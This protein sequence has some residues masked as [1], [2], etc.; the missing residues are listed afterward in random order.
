MTRVVRIGK[1]PLIEKAVGH[2]L[3][4]TRC[5]VAETPRNGPF[6]GQTSFCQICPDVTSRPVRLLTTLYGA[7]DRYSISLRLCSAST[8]V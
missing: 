7:D 4:G 3:N 5:T 2:G 8:T 6:L 1:G